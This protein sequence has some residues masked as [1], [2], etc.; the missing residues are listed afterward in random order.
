MDRLRQKGRCLEDEAEGIRNDEIKNDIKVMLEKELSGKS[1]VIWPQNSKDIPD[2]V[3]AFQ[4]AYLP[5]EFVYEKNMEKIG[6]EFLMQYGDKP[7]IYKNGLALAIPD[8][9]QIKPLR[10]A[11]RYLIAAQLSLI[12]I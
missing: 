9:N 10:R 12:H 3:P 11:V 1:A 5:I 6:I 4:I 2:K 7:R 8:K